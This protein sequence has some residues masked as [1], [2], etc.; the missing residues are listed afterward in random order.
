MARLFAAHFLH[1][2]SKKSG[3]DRL[4]SKRGEKIGENR[5]AG[6]DS[7]RVSSD[8][9]KRFG[10]PAPTSIPRR[11]MF[12]EQLNVQLECWVLAEKC[13]RVRNVNRC[14]PFS[15][16]PMYTKKVSIYRNARSLISRADRL[17][18]AFAIIYSSSLSP[19][20]YLCVKF[21][22]HLI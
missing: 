5:I 16:A 12:Y 11:F 18:A 2:E 22:K 7:R 17:L 1:V 15:L 6:N 3:S 10:F 9:N 13:V 4:A 8:L 20:L 19:I 14:V 21:L